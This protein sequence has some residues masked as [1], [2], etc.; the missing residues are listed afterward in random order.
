MGI[1]AVPSFYNGREVLVGAQP[2][3]AL[4][5]FIQI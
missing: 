3:Q 2:L 4:E 1:R 5:R